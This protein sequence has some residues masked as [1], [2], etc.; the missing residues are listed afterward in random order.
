VSAPDEA[1]LARACV[2]LAGRDTA[3]ARAYDEIGIP[4][5][6]TAAPDYETLARAVAYQLI[7][8]IAAA[9]IWARVRAFLG[10]DISAQTVLA[11]D[12]DDLRA[13]GMSRPKV[14]HMRSIAVAVETGALCF[15]RLQKADPNAARRELL[16]VGGIGPWTAELFLMNALGQID[17]FPVGDVGVMEAYKRLSR[18]E[19]RHSAK[20][21]TA[22]AEAWRPY[23][24]VGAHLLWGWLNATR[25]KS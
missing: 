14:A 6:R 15:E 12:M 25:N 17:A 5:W 10:E 20:D 3:L 9:A 23:R 1:A 2:E 4:V 21:F 19:V 18:A 11:A 8:T 16:A 13:C 24:G 7:S 22:L